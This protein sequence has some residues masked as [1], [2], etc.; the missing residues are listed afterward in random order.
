MHYAT[1]RLEWVFGGSAAQSW[2]FFCCLQHSPLLYGYLFSAAL[3]GREGYEEKKSSTQI[4]TTCIKPRGGHLLL[5][6]FEAG[7]NLSSVLKEVKMGERHCLQ[8][9]THFVSLK[10]GDKFLPGN[11]VHCQWREVPLKQRSNFIMFRNESLWKDSPRDSP[12]VQCC[13]W[14]LK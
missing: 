13:L 7:M 1:N 9:V 3:D 10:L 12:T 14:D 5:M 11:T 8:S 4:W 6:I 2:L